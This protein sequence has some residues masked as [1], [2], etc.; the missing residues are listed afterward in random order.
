MAY[1]QKKRFPPNCNQMHEKALYA[2]NNFHILWIGTIQEGFYK[3]ECGGISGSSAEIVE[4]GVMF[5]NKTVLGNF[6]K[7]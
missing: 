4:R 6:R 3:Q 1:E 7:F 5:L 2:P